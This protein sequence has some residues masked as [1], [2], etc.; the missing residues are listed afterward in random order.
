MAESVLDASALLAYFQNEPGA[1]KVEDALEREAAI[2]VVNV[3]EILGKL[4]EVGISPT[5]AIARVD[6]LAEVLVVYPLTNEDLIESARLR[7]VTKSAGLSLADRICIALARRLGVP[8]LTTDRAWSNLK[9][10]GL[11][12]KLL[13]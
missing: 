9:L 7:P 6:A 10:D 2:S 4:A 8:V 5:E 3:A 11:T 12:V 1:T 13:R